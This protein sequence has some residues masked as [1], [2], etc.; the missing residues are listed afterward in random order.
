M[1]PSVAHKKMGEQIHV[2]SSLS[3]R[4]TGTVGITNA[5]LPSVVG[6]VSKMDEY[7]LAL[8]D[9]VSIQFPNIMYSCM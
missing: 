6:L 5:F 4:E 1:S 9:R 7:G 3:V 2:A 8:L